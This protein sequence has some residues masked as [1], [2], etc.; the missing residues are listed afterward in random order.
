M[1]VLIF[2]EYTHEKHN[3]AAK[4]V[5]PNGLHAALADAV[6]GP[7]I[8]VEIVTMEMENCGITKEKL[9]ETDVLIWWSH[10]SHH[11]VPD[12]VSALV[13]AAVQQGM[14]FIALHSS[15]LCKPLRGLLGT[16]G[17]LTWRDG[18]RER[19]WC[20]NPAHPIAK[21]LPAYFELP[22]EEM[23]GEFFDIPTPDELVFIG[24]FAGGEVFRSGCCWQRGLG[25]VFY[26]QPGHETY[27]VYYDEN[28][29]KVLKN[30]VEWAA[31]AVR[32]PSL[33]CPHAGNPPEAAHQ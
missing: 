13:V 19:L 7:G 8:S 17:R 27:P 22:K 15:H 28:I 6:Q 24:W 14:G 12:A 10:A 29:K 23:Y 5:Y 26:F 18:D 30:A 2:N 31:P 16:S 32:I 21:G 4:A 33:D 3:A 25:K 9:A 11:E 1:K 20:C